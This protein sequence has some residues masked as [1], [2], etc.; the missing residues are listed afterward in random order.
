LRGDR[1]KIICGECAQ[2]EQST[3][4]GRVVAAQESTDVFVVG[5]ARLTGSRIAPG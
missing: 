1:D 3:E 2:H 4:G 5:E